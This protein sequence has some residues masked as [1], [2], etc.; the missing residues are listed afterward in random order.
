MHELEGEKVMNAVTG[1]VAIVS[2]LLALAGGSDTTKNQ[3]QAWGGC[4]PFMCGT[5]GNHNETLVRDAAPAE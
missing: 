2:L 5:D 3:P 1:F 4:P